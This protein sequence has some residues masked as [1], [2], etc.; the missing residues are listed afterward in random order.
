[1]LKNL[2]AT[3]CALIMTFTFNNLQAEESTCYGTTKK[4]RLE[5]GV[6]LPAKGNNFKAYSILAGWLG[7]TFVHSKVRDVILEA[8]QLLETEQPNKVFKYAETGYKEG[9]EFKPHKTHQNGLSVDFIVPVL[10]EN[11]NSVQ[12]PTNAFNKYGY[13]VEFDDEGRYQKYEIDFDALGAHIMAL[14][15][16]A[17]KQGI[18]I[19]R[20]IFDPRLQAKLYETKY[21]GYIK[22]HITI[23]KKKSWV[24]H[25]DH[26]HVDFTVDCKPLE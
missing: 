15:K 13:A 8:Y 12:L 19:W 1:M 5:R 17:V 6:K 14:H 23:P 16:A 2:F 7:R 3:I 20:V 18:G 25:D 22:Q 11:G 24:R 4:G 21:S 26:Y 9:G 10:D